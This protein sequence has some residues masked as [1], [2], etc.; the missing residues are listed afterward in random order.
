[1]VLC[2]DWENDGAQRSMV[3]FLF[4]F[5]LSWEMCALQ[6]FG[7]TI[8]AYKVCTLEYESTGKQLSRLASRDQQDPT[9]TTNVHNGQ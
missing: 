5:Q 9:Q 8:G 4:S 6:W 3:V 1:M 2:H 7:V